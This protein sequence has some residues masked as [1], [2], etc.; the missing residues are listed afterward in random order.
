[1]F[2]QILFDTCLD[3]VLRCWPQNSGKKR[4]KD[5]L[6]SSQGDGKTGKR[7]KPP[8]KVSDEVRRSHR[9]RSEWAEL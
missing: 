8:K 2:H 3:L 5:T 7:P 9:D 1:M 4:K 6:K